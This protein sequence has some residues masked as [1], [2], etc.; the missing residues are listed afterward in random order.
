[1]L[2]V[3]EVENQTLLLGVIAENFNGIILDGT[4]S[5]YDSFIDKLIIAK[6]NGKKVKVSGIITNVGRAWKYVKKREKRNW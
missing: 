5:N 6:E 1:M 2:V 3:L 4:L